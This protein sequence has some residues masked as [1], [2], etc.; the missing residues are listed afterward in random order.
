MVEFYE[1]IGKNN[2]VN[3]DAQICMAHAIRWNAEA[4]FIRPAKDDKGFSGGIFN[5][6]T[7]KPISQS[8]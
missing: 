8:Y 1:I 4:M 5:E 3:H 7:F 6:N 2:F